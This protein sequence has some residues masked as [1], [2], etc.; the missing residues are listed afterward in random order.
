MC[1]ADGTPSTER[2][3]CVFHTFVF[4]LRIF[5]NR[6]CIFLLGYDSMGFAMSKPNLRAELEASLKGCVPFDYSVCTDNHQTLPLAISGDIDT[7][8]TILLYRFERISLI[9]CGVVF[10]S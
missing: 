9:F 2:H 4:T 7:K 5:P 1:G 10:I 6:N 3:S 8:E